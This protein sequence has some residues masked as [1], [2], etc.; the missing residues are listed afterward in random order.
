[1]ILQ[2]DKAELKPHFKEVFLSLS[3]KRTAR[4]QKICH[5]PLC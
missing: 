3:E 2:L 1:M 4:L 5:N